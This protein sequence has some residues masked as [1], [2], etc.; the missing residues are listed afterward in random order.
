MPRHAE[1][2]APFGRED[3]SVDRLQGDRRLEGKIE[4]LADRPLQPPL[5]LAIKLTEGRAVLER[6]R[7]VDEV[8]LR[9]VVQERPEHVVGR[10]SARGDEVGHDAGVLRDGIENAR[11]PA[12]A[13]L[14]REGMRDV[15]GI[16]VGR[17]GLERADAPPADRLDRAVRLQARFTRHIVHRSHH[18]GHSPPFGSCRTSPARIRCA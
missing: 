1:Q 12:E 13:T 6:V 5:H 10:G 2:L 17:L 7:Q 3:A 4:P 11:M 18:E 8:G 14:V 15:G 16:D 9:R